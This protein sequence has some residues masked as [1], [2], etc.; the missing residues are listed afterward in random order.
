M[1]RPLF[2]LQKIRT[3][4]AYNKTEILER[5]DMPCLIELNIFLGAAAAFHGRCL[6]RGKRGQYAGYG[7]RPDSRSGPHPLS[8]RVAGRYD[9]TAE[10]GSGPLVHGRESGHGLSGVGPAGAVDHKHHDPCQIR[11]QREST[12]RSK[13]KAFVYRHCNRSVWR[14]GADHGFEPV[15]FLSVGEG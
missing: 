14:G 2:V 13:N 15:S 1:R 12:Q 8:E 9:G 3:P 6:C 10:S 11:G 5:E 4:F 7:I